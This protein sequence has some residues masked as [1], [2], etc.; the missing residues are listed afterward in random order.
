MMAFSTIMPSSAS[1]FAP[2]LASGLILYICIG[3]FINYRKL[4]QFKGPPLAAVSEVWLWKQ[5]IAKRMHTAEAEA[6]QKY[7]TKRDL[8]LFSG[9]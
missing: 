6:L 8:P 2:L 9:R 3:F 7:G 1:A 5:S 4:S